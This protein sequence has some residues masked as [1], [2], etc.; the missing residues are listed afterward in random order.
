MVMIAYL[1]LPQPE[2]KSDLDP[3]QKLHEGMK[4]DMS[5]TVLAQ[6]ISDDGHGCQVNA[7]CGELESEG[8]L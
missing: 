4:M 5:T 6:F 8:L 7:K 1:E 3:F 2:L